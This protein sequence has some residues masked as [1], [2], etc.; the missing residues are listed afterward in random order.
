MY[1]QYLLLP[2]RKELFHMEAPKI[3]PP[4]PAGLHSVS[5]ILSTKAMRGP[6]CTTYHYMVRSHVRLRLVFPRRKRPATSPTKKI[7]ARGLKEI[8]QQQGL[9]TTIT[10]VLE[11]KGPNNID[12]AVNVEHS[13]ITL[14][15]TVYT[16]SMEVL[17]HPARRTPD[18]FQDNSQEIHNSLGEK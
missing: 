5:E 12:T 1:Y 8:D 16:T 2:I 11:A 6:K 17:R 9:A 10:E 4:S 13:W 15:E 18:R 3:Q 14:K 7:N